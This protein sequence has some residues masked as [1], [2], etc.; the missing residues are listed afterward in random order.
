MDRPIVFV[1]EVPLDTDFLTACKSTMIGLGMALQAIL[2]GSTVLD[3]LA[4]TPTGP[5]SLTV[6]IGQGSIYSTVNVDGSAYGSLGSD[7]AHQIVKQGIV[8]GTTTLPA[9]GIIGV[10][11]TTGQSV[12]YLVQVQYQD[13]DTGATVLPYYD[14]ANPAVAFSGPA[15]AGTPQ[16]NLRQG[17]V[18]IQ[19]K[20]G[21]AATTGTQVTPTPDSGFTGIWV[22]TVANGATTITSGNIALYPGAP[23]INYKLPQLS[24]ATAGAARTLLSGNTTY[25]VAA[26][27]SDSAAGTVG[28]PWQTIQ[29]AV[30]VILSTIDLGGFT[31]TISVANG[32]YTA[33]LSLSEPFTGGGNVILQG[34][35]GSPS[36]C[37]IS[38]TSAD[39]IAVTNS[40]LSVEG[41]KLQTTTAG[42]GLV[43]YEE[44]TVYIA[45]GMNFG[46]CAGA[47]I[48]AQNGG[49]VRSLSSYSI[50]GNAT[51]H[52][53]FTT[54][55]LFNQQ[56]GT[57]TLSGT[58]N[59]T[60]AFA[61]GTGGGQAV[62]QG[63]RFS[64]SATGLEFN[65]QANA[66]INTLGAGASYLPGGTSG[67]T[68][69]GGQ[70]V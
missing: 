51:A 21:V 65:L 17:K 5:A 70:Y 56:T 7:T 41:F 12:N 35:T 10:P 3:G 28:A 67:T 49:V 15:N 47:Q 66:V 33:G 53:Y 22:I 8:L 61:F 30:N 6:L 20:A 68:A 4:C 52:V 55:G 25:Y 31:A 63:V 37:I 29:H 9:T 42:N 48:S 58:P 57:V 24:P 11:S 43:A 60:T 14:A 46:V 39:A 62:I 13:V 16:N 69:T 36:S 19:L 27:G 59:F 1:D 40:S 50:S 64:G 32:T 38:R 18:V 44:G 45:G 23:F 26:S 54:G 2:G 34:N